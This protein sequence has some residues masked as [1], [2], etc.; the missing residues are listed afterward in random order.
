MDRY[1]KRLIEVDLPIR[2]L[3]I[4]ATREK[5]SRRGHIPQL[6][7][8]PAARPTAACR[9]IACA[10]LWTDP[11]DM[12]EWNEEAWNDRSSQ[13]KVSSSKYLTGLVS[14]LKPFAKAVAN[15]QR[16]NESLIADLQVDLASKKA[17]KRQRA[18]KEAEHR[19]EF[20][21][22]FGSKDSYT[23]AD[24][25]GALYE[26]I[27][28]FAGWEQS[29]HGLWLDTVRQIT[30]LSAESLGQPVGSPFFVVDPFAGGGAIPLEAVRLG[31][32]T[33]SSD[34]NPVAATIN[35]VLLEF[36]PLHGD[37]LVAHVRGWLSWVVEQATLRLS[38]CY[39]PSSGEETPTAYL[40]ARTILS[41]G[42][43]IDG[44]AIEI[45]LLRSMRL[46]RRRRDGDWYIRWKRNSGGQILLE[47]VCERDVNGKRS[48]ILRP[49][50]EIFRTK[51]KI[52]MDDGTILGGAATCPITGHT[53]PVSSVRRQL[54]NRHGGSSDS[55]LYC[56]VFD[57]TDGNRAFRLPTRRDFESLDEAEKLLHAV[58]PSGDL[59][60]EPLP[61]QGTNGFRVQR[62]GMKRWRDLYTPRQL[63]CLKTYADLVG[64]YLDSC[65]DPSDS[66]LRAGLAAVLSLIIGRLADLNA[67]LCVW[68]LNTPNTAHVFGRWALPMV[69][70]FG[71]INPLAGVGGSPGSV[72]KRT[73]RILSHIAQGITSLGHVTMCDAER[74][75]LPDDVGDLLFTDPPYYDAIPYSDLLDF[76]LVWHKQVG[77][78]DNYGILE[79]G[80]GPKTAE[81]VVDLSK[82]KD[83]A[84]FF[85][86][87]TA[88]M[89]EAR[90]VISPDGLG[91]IVFAHKST[92]GWEA[93][94]SSMVQAGWVI[95]AS[96]PIDTEMT[97]RLR[98]KGSAALA[99]SVHLVCRPRE[100]P[101]GSLCT[102]KIG[103]W[104]DVLAELPE[105]IHEWMSRLAAE[106]V[107]GA[108]AIFS[109]LGP[110][111][112]IYT[113]YSSV[114]KASGEKVEL[115]EYLEQVWAAVS[116]EALDM[117]FEGADASGFEEDARL[118]AMWLWTL[119][120]SAESDEEADGAGE[121]TK[122]VRGYSLE[123]DA[124]RKIAQGLGAHLENLDHLVEIKG[125]TA[126]LLSAAARTRYLFGKD[127]AEAPKGRRKKKKKSQL[128]LEFEQELK[129]LEEKSGD[130]TGE[131][132]GGA[133]STVLDQLHQSMILFAAGR[134]EALKHF[135][136]EDGV[137]RD[138]RFW[139]LAQALSALYPSATEE[140]RWVDGVL[141]RK[142]GL[143]F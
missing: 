34:L 74:L 115:K 98:A 25:R 90:R 18:R 10:A 20:W 16:G 136:V 108:D 31:C 124:A 26:L 19:H 137:G 87:M 57:S 64:E 59:L 28:A 14:I 127:S 72:V 132:S 101:D 43:G 5:E 82:N 29:V 45:P 129:E 11:V 122:S 114:E 106:G 142:K 130:W 118:T 27:V 23:P 86:K 71:E 125:A 3:S 68:Q 116:R 121:K 13:Q 60:S 44:K 58:D 99:S 140:K 103:D 117:I 62:Y 51:E 107:V 49:E 35:R 67:S 63:L 46:T 32:Q 94:L 89:T 76:F 41:E 66:D 50:F 95:S 48:S 37:K 40:W 17:E 38:S 135:L 143:G 2:R 36:L 55:R 9:A 97:S 109:C 104:R 22:D 78:I 128:S 120:T 12:A 56:V 42:P 30:K 79:Q 85:T 77:C 123:Y 4:Q 84:F 69:F 113:R 110:A 7:I 80:L 33:F 39:Q 8:Y 93:L 119:R 73:I 105:R 47:E 133:G 92:A 21:H 70:D 112:E 91:V 61:K 83:H 52:S 126:T 65:V 1:C 139:R 53:T 6:H 96:W 134:G 54:D 138:P 15:T 81:C 75:V 141:A 24:L 131:L 100:N 88:A 102:H 111:L